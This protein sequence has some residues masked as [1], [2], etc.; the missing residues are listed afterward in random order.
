MRRGTS[1]IVF[2]LILSHIDTDFY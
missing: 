2:D 1:H